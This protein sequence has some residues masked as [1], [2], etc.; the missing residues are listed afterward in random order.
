MLKPEY[1]YGKSDKAIQY[2]QEL[3]DFLLQRIAEFMLT[4][5]TIGGTADK[6][7]QILQY[8]GLSNDEIV[9]ELSKISKKST[10]AVKEVLQDSVM[11][12]FSNDKDV[13][14][15]VLGKEINP[16][17]NSMVL[18]AI[19]AEW[20]KTQGDLNNLTKTTINKAQ[21]D[22]LNMLNEAEMRVDSGSEG[23]SQ[24]VC[25]ILDRY[26]ANGMTV[27]YMSGFTRSLESAVRACVVTSMNQTAAQVTNQ[28]IV[29]GGIEYVMVTA[30]YGARHSKKGGLYSH[31]EW[32]GKAYK[33]VGSAK[34]F[35]NLA[36]ATG[37]TINPVTGEGTVLNPAGLHGV[38]CRHSHQ[39]WFPDMKNPWIDKDGKPLVD[40]NESQKVYE[41]QQEQRAMERSIRQ[42]KRQLNMKQ[43]E[44]NNVAE[45]DIKSILQQD[46]DA[47]AYKLREQNKAYNTFCSEK[48]LARQADRLKVGGFTAKDSA[49]AHGRATAYVNELNSKIRI[50]QIP[51]STIS[52]KVKSGEY[53][54]NLSRQ[55]YEKHK[56]GT[57]KFNEYA[58]SRKNPQSTLSI[59]FEE[60][61]KIIENKAGTGIIKVD[62]HGN[63]RPQE[64]ITCDSIIGSY[65]GGGKYH[66]TKKA[67]IHYSKKGSHLVPIKGDNYD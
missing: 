41:A 29:E 19:N 32:Q 38:N 25:D 49:K 60:V 7:L 47:L 4:S 67:V 16:L 26:A 43:I 61:Q 2:Y 48:N 36:E 37:Y 42:T 33:I 22:L 50:P 13:L 56:I 40:I 1:F 46:Y 11:T 58:H 15:R 59:S 55:Q 24:A 54:L 44:I 6:Y 21:I 52:K 23:Y 39:P 57:I 35:P 18:Q 53:S 63:P 28:Y 3:E 30:H 31:D 27:E 12:S 20:I 45:T 8:M 14:A 10:R 64:Q 62:R 51:S 17:K 9:K 65:Y 66:N 5:E 34:G